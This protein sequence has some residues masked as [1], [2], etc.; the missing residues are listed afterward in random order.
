MMQ[1]T[2]GMEGYASITKPRQSFEFAGL[3]EVAV[4]QSRALLCIQR[5]PYIVRCAFPAL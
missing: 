1:G 5:L 4:D 2:K 3:D